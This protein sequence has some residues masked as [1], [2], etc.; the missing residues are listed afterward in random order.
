MPIESMNM[1]IEETVRDR[2]IDRSPE[3]WKAV[4]SIEEVT[5]W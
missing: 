2:N 1:D 5:Y 4:T 3:P